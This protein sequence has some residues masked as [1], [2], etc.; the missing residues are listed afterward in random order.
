MTARVMV[1]EDRPASGVWVSIH[2]VVTSVSDAS[3]AVSLEMYTE[4]V[5]LAAAVM[6][7]AFVTVQETLMDS[8]RFDSAGPVAV[9]VRSGAG[10]WNG[11][12]CTLLFS[13]VSPWLLP[14]SVATNKYWL[15]GNAVNGIR[16]C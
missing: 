6:S 3:N 16:T 4:S 1:Y 14:P 12:A 15:P 13:F 8:P 5:Q 10:N 11:S 2:S 7:L 9:M